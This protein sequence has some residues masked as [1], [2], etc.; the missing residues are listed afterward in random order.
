MSRTNILRASCGHGVRWCEDRMQFG[1]VIL[2][3]TLE[4]ELICCTCFREAVK[5]HRQNGGSKIKRVLI[6]E[7]WCVI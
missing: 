4:P 5:E 2:T 6:H 3:D 7:E 1:Y